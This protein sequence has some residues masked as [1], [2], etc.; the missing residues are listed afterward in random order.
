MNMIKKIVKG[1]FKWFKAAVIDP[2]LLYCLAYPYR[3]RPA[4]SGG[5]HININCPVAYYHPAS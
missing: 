3:Y 1:L 4:G 2:W 5:S